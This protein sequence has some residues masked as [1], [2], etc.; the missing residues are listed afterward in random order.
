M[1]YIALGIKVRCL[2]INSTVSE[3]NETKLEIALCLFRKMA[4]YDSSTAMHCCNTSNIAVNL[5]S[6]LHLPDRRLDDV[7]IAAQLHDLGKMKIPKQILNKPQKLTE[8]EFEL[9][10]KHS[11]IGFSIVKNLPEFYD[12]AEAILYHHERFDG[13]GYPTGKSSQEIPL[14][15]RI[16]SIADAYEAMTSNRIYRKALTKENAQQIIIREK[17]IHFDPDIVNAFIAMKKL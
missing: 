9:I 1:C 17:G 7:L 4:N 6:K 16:L 12:I 14:Y 13:N 5:A 3:K 10:K 15:A 11:E 2:I 8:N